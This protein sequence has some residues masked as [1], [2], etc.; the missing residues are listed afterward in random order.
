MYVMTSIFWASSNFHDPLVTRDYASPSKFKNRIVKIQPSRL[1]AH[2][3]KVK[4]RL[5]HMLNS[6][7]R[8]LKGVMGSSLQRFR[9]ENVQYK[10]EFSRSLIFVL[11]YV[12]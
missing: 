8:M 3:G 1:I 4:G 7:V 5:G 12:E 11:C 10:T 6:S 2:S 9:G